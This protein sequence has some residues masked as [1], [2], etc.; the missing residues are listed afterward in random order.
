MG[1]QPYRAALLLPIH[2]HT[3]FAALLFLNKP[4]HS[5]K[6]ILKCQVNKPEDEKRETD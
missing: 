1:K 2:L 5:S 4:F 6:I 3:P